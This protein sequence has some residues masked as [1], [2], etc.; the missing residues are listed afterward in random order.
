MERSHCT[1]RADAPSVGSPLPSSSAENTVHPRLA[2]H[3]EAWERKP[4]LRAVYNDYHRRLLDACPD[5]PILEIGS[6][7]GHLKTLAR[8]VVS[9]DIL[10]SPWVDTVADA[11]QLPYAGSTFSAIV[12]IDVLHHL[13]RPAEFF[14]EAARVLRPGGRLTMIE[15][16][17]TPLSWPFYHFIHEEPVNLAVDPLADVV[18]QGDRDPF[19]SNQAIPTL[20]FSRKDGQ[21]RFSEMFPQLSISSR[22]WLS[23]FAYPLTGGFKPWSLV[24]ARLVKPLLRLEGVLSPIVGGLLAFRLLIVLERLDDSAFR[25]SLKNRVPSK[26][27]TP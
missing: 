23:L 2:E 4:S 8:D 15:P 21:K 5:G 17:I 7:S 9:L 12:M 18:K 25:F 11:H 24:P 20:L 1:V 6:G 19:D 14:A 26:S 22:E 16:A 10:P 3:R 13:E 27:V